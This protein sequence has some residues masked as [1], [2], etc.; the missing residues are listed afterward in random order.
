MID[1]IRE[2]SVFSKINSQELEK[3]VK[4]GEAV[5]FQDGEKIFNAGDNA[6]YMYIVGTG[7][8]KLK[9]SVNHLNAPMILT[10]DTIKE[11]GSLGWSAFTK[12]YKYTLSAYANGYTQLLRLQTDKIRKLCDDD[13]NLGFIIM[14]NITTMISARFARLQGLMQHVIQSYL[15]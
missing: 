4:I 3:I 13:R 14:K 11:K 5:E 15:E 12:P 10:L 2:S 1:L 9:F 8:V 6:D 7:E